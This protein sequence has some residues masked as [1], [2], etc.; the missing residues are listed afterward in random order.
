MRRYTV[1]AS[2]DSDEWPFTFPG[3]INW[4]L[5]QACT[6]FLLSM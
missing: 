1:E 6:H 3:S 4:T 2:R 5:G